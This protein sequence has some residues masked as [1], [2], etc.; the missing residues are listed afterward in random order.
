M[1][2][3]SRA[4]FHS[5]SG[6][7][8]SPWCWQHLLNFWALQESF[9]WIC[10]GSSSV[11]GLLYHPSPFQ[12]QCQAT[13]VGARDRER[14]ERKKMRHSGRPQQSLASSLVFPHS[15][16]GPCKQ[17]GSAS[18]HFQLMLSSLPSR[19]GQLFLFRSSC[20]EFNLSDIAQ[21]HWVHPSVNNSSKRVVKTDD[22]W[23]QGW[24]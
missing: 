6:A 5:H 18:L 10:T 2:F 12:S 21:V 19:R 9:S 4:A 20:L 24:S 7:A 15:P 1:G 23:G 8:E 16:C 11:E 14:H 22:A 3:K 13:L 17:Q